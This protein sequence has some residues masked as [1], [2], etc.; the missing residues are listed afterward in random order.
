MRY[1]LST[2]SP[3]HDTSL[4]FSFCGRDC[5]ALLFQGPSR[6]RRAGGGKARRGARRDARAFDVSTRTYCRRTPQ[7][8]RAV[9]GHGCPVTAGARGSFLWLLSFG[10]AKESNSAA[11]MAVETTHGRESVFAKI[12]PIEEQSQNGSRLSPERRQQQSWIPAFAGMTKPEA[13]PGKISEE[14][15]DSGFR[16][17]DELMFFVGTSSKSQMGSAFHRNDG[18]SPERRQ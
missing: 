1:R 14:Q 7:P 10:Q 15:M 13:F 12:K 17:N 18:K 16:R 11:R 8:A 4:L 2:T 9:T 3:I 5:R 6:P